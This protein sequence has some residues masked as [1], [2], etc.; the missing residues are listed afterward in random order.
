MRLSRKQ[1]IINYCMEKGFTENAMK[2]LNAILEITDNGI[3]DGYALKYH[4]RVI[5]EAF[6][7]ESG[8]YFNAYRE[9]AGSKIIEI[10]GIHLVILA[11]D[12]NHLF[13]LN[14]NLPRRKYAKDPIRGQLQLD[15][16]IRKNERKHELLDKAEDKLN[17]TCNWQKLMG[18]IIPRSLAPYLTGRSYSK[19]PD[20]IDNMIRNNDAMDL[21]KEEIRRY[22]ALIAQCVDGD[23]HYYHQAHSIRL[24]KELFGDA[25]VSESTCYDVDR[26][27]LEKGLISIFDDG[28][29]YKRLRIN[30]Y[31]DGFGKGKNYVAVPYAVFQEDFKL[32]E[33]GAIKMFFDF[34][35]GL[36]NGENDGRKIGAGKQ[37]RRKIFSTPYDTQEDKK[38]CKW[39][40]AWLRRRC[41]DEVSELLLGCKR[42]SGLRQFFYIDAESDKK[43]GIVNIRIRERYFVSK[44]LKEFTQG[45]DPLIRFRRKAELIKQLLGNASF[46]YTE[47]DLRDF[48]MVFRTAT[49]R[50]IEI[51]L[52][53]LDI[54]IRNRQQRRWKQIESKGGYLREMYRKYLAGDRVLIFSRIEE[55]NESYKAALEQLSEGAE[56]S[57]A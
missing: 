10:K 22:I 46:Q 2:L 57:E 54:D 48:V 50:I 18:V 34:I 29:G 23:I 43:N 32:L 17:I 12:Y 49:R 21:D 14:S 31:K 26:K 36:N 20:T 19:N 5:R 28:E 13:A 30:G 11:W 52:R 33:I 4:E 15:G 39:L 16:M 37:I 25:T 45:F 7:G 24:M 44:G 51:L 53:T 41:N 6:K 1:R 8:H 55:I 38:K 42:G 35:F 40:Q 9:L 56:Y 27:L 3:I 47:K